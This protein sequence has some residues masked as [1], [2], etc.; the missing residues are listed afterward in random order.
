MAVT[1]ISAADMPP[2]F[3]D[4]AGTTWQTLV[5]ITD[6]TLNGATTTNETETFC[7]K[8]TSTGQPGMTGSANAVANVTPESTEVSMEEAV[9]WW[10]N[11]TSLTF[12]VQHPGSGT[13]GTN[14]FISGSA[15]ITNVTL[16]GTAG[17][18]VNFSIDW[19]I[20]GTID[21]TPA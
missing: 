13:P 6:W 9:N 11:K 16:T 21:N 18:D 14:L 17:Q 19:A 20:Q 5:C 2:Q 10:V 8:F 7:G 1:R 15:L 12:R 3:S 4:D